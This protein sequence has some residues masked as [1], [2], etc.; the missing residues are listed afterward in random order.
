LRSFCDLL[1]SDGSCRRSV[2]PQLMAVDSSAHSIPVT[3]NTSVSYT[4][5]SSQSTSKRVNTTASSGH[6][7]DLLPIA[8]RYQ[9]L[10]PQNKSLLHVGRDNHR[11]WSHIC[12]YT[13]IK[14]LKSIT[15]FAVGAPRM[16][17]TYPVLRKIE[18]NNVL[19]NR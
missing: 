9:Y 8:L 15:T 11:S 19:S 5:S 3:I 18:I 1:I 4:T 10:V 17:L 12:R 13:L 14:A 16:V 6:N 7:V 2:R